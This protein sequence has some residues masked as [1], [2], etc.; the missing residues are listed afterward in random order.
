MKKI[1]L[2]LSTSFLVN[3]Y[4]TNE[5][6]DT[7]ICTAT[8]YSRNGVCENRYSLREFRG[9]VTL[10]ARNCDGTYARRNM[11]GPIVSV[12]YE[13]LLHGEKITIFAKAG[14]IGL[15]GFSFAYVDQLG[16]KYIRFNNE[17][18]ILCLD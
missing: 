12:N 17:E 11:S 5:S 13:A 14:N 7:I 15:P 2:L 8:E 18:S 6:V 16:D 1:A 4:A 3:S 10:L 9:R